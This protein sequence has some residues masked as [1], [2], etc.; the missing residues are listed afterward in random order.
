MFIC[1]L[2]G[3]KRFIKQESWINGKV[4]DKLV[5]YSLA[6]VCLRCGFELIKHELVKPKA[7]DL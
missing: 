2:F 6:P 1:W 4:G 3:H 7:S 5:E